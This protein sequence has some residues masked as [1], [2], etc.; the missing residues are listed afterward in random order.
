M[1]TTINYGLKKPESTDFYNVND[2]NE[3]FD[4]IDIAL[5][6]NRV[7]EEERAAWNGKAEASHSQ[8]ASTIT[9][10]TLGGQVVAY[11]L[12]FQP[13][14]QKIKYNYL[15]ILAVLRTILAK[16]FYL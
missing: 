9:A 14:F 5:R 6:E 13:R 3:N 10:G 11:A 4:V 1:K 12:N 2:F 7:T 8:T 16:L 15:I